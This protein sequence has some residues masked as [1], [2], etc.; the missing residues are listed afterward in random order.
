MAGKAVEQP[1]SDP[2]SLVAAVAHENPGRNSTAGV[3]YDLGPRS[4]PNPFLACPFVWCRLISRSPCG[5]RGHGRRRRGARSPLGAQRRREGHELC[6][7]G[8]NHY[9]RPPVVQLIA[10]FAEPRLQRPLGAAPFG[11]ELPEHIAA[12]LPVLSDK[13]FG[14]LGAGI[15]V[16]QAAG[17]EGAMALR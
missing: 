2:S 10:D 9:R 16:V 17:G 14:Q 4:F 15:S 11:D 3:T 5:L 12:S 7:R 8:G 1:A 13:P 6:R